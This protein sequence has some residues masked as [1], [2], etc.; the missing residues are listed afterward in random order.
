MRWFFTGNKEL[1]LVVVLG[2]A[3][4]VFVSFHDSIEISDAEVVIEHTIHHPEETLGFPSLFLTSIFDLQVVQ[5]LFS[6]AIHLHS[7]QFELHGV[8]GL[9]VTRFPRCE[10]EIVISSLSLFAKIAK[11]LSK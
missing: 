9:E 3:V 11:W 1:G 8:Q 4:D 6:E 10:S 7:L 5:N 2:H